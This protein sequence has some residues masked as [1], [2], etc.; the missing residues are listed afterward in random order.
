M[1][2]PSSY[3]LTRVN[4]W[5]LSFRVIALLNQYNRMEVK[6]ANRCSRR[7]LLSSN[8]GIQCQWWI[9]QLMEPLSP[10]QNRRCSW[11]SCLLSLHRRQSWL[12][13]MFW[14][15]IPRKF[16]E[17]EG[18]ETIDE[19]PNL[20]HRVL[21]VSTIIRQWQLLFWRHWFSSTLGNS[22]FLLSS[23]E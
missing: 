23:G 11:V 14:G 7:E 18:G 5:S 15:K 12:D 22:K 10:R 6:I 13:K 8:Q 9:S 4:L 17:F 21:N 19:I 1:V 16:E 20:I 3:D 2:K